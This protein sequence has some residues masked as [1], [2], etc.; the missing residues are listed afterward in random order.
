MGILLSSFISKLQ[1]VLNEHGDVY[2]NVFKP[3]SF[4]DGELE[5]TPAFITLSEDSNEKVSGVTIV[6]EETAVSFL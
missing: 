1:N 2:V 5:T 6:D 3:E 4:E